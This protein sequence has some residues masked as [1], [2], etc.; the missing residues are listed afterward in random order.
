[1]EALNVIL[2]T[3]AIG[4]VLAWFLYK[5]EPRLRAVEQS[6]EG[7]KRAMLLLTLSLPTA[8]PAAKREA[9]R[10]LDEC[11][12]GDERPEIVRAVR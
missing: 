4:A 8:T 9:Q 5:L 10:M 1:M 11:P 7:L 6:N 12:A 3:G 2:Q